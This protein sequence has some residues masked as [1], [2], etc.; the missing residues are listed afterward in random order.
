MYTMDILHFSLLAIQV[1]LLSFFPAS[2]ISFYLPYNRQVSITAGFAL[3]LLLFYLSSFAAYYFNLPAAYFFLAITAFSAFIFVIKIYGSKSASFDFKLPLVFF[4]FYLILAVSQTLIPYYA[5]GYWYFDWFEHYQ[6]SLF[7]LDHLPLDFRFGPYLLTAR[8]PFFNLVASFFMEFTGRNFYHYQL[9]ATLL[10]ALVILPVYLIS[11]DHLKLNRYK[12]LL[13]IVFSIV[14]FNPAIFQQTTFTWTKSLS[15]F[16][17]ILGFYFYLDHRKEQRFLSLFLSFIFLAQAHLVHYS[18]VG[19]IIPIIFAALI[20]SVAQFKKFFVRYV[21]CCFVFLLILSSWYGFALKNYG[22]YNTFAGN[23][24]YEWTKNLSL[25]D[26]INKDSLNFIY[27][28]FPLIPASYLQSIRP[29]SSMLVKLY[30]L[31]V[32]F[33]YGNLPGTLT[34]TL[35][36]LIIVCFLRIILKRFNILLKDKKARFTAFFITIGTIIN[37]VVYPTPSNAI[38]GVVFF[39]LSLL[40]LCFGIISLIRLSGTISRLFWKFIVTAIFIES[41]LGIL[42]KIYILQTELN[43][44]FNYRLTDTNRYQ[45]KTLAVHLDNWYLKKDNNLVFLYDRFNTL[46]PLF[47]SFLLLSWL[48]TFLLLMKIPPAKQ[49]PPLHEK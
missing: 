6:R 11:R 37:L 43:P 2:L 8:P 46:Q 23:T 10:N 26:R 40:L 45:Y 1:F 32:Y 22:V 14:L 25:K 35:Y 31:A 48:T 16:F 20:S 15:A 41:I 30:D 24:S 33:Y 44:Q 3:S 42:L 12:Y 4:I 17:V 21:I 7:F 49:G 5:G 47:I 36:L 27:T 34:V 29:Q 19:Y 39:P 13:S 28:F 38:A 18:A 9:I